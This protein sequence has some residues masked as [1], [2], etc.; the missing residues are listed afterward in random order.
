[1][2]AI[3]A[4]T[5]AGSPRWITRPL[6]PALLAYLACA[7]PALSTL[8]TSPANGPEPETGSMSRSRDR[9]KHRACIRPIP[10]TNRL[11]RRANDT[12]AYLRGDTLWTRT[13]PP[14]PANAVPLAS[15][16][17]LHE[18]NL[19]VPWQ[20]D[21]GT[22]LARIVADDTGGY[23]LL[24]PDGTAGPKIARQSG[25][26]WEMVD[27][28][29]NYVS[30]SVLAHFVSDKITSDPRTLH[31]AAG[32][33]EGMQLHESNL[34]ESSQAPISP[35]LRQS[36]QAT[37][38]L[39]VGQSFVETLPARLRDRDASVWTPNEVRIVAPDL[40]RHIGRPLAVYRD[41]GLFDFAVSADGAPVS[42]E[43]VPANA[44]R[45]NYDDANRYGRRGRPS[46]EYPS[47]FAAIEAETRASNSF[48]AMDASQQEHLF[49][50]ELA[51]AIEATPGRPRLERMHEHW[52]NPLP[53]SYL[54]KQ[55]LIGYSRLRQALFDRNQPLRADQENFL[56]MLLHDLL[57]RDRRVAIEVVRHD[58]G[59]RGERLALIGTPNPAGN[60][61]V[62]EADLDGEGRRIAYYQ[63]G[64]AGNGAIRSRPTTDNSFSPIID[65]LLNADNG[66]VR[67]AL[68]LGEWDFQKFAD[69]LLA[70][71]VENENALIPASLQRLVV[72]NPTV[73]TDATMQSWDSW[74][75]NG[76]HYVRLRN[77]AGRTQIVETGAPAPDG[78]RE[79]LDY[80]NYAAVRERGHHLLRERRGLWF[81]SS[82]IRAGFDPLSLSFRR[83]AAMSIVGN[84]PAHVRTDVATAA[85]IADAIPY[86]V[87]KDFMSHPSP[88]DVRTNG[89]LAL[90]VGHPISRTYLTRID[91][92]GRPIPVA[93]PAVATPR[94]ATPLS[95]QHAL[96]PAPQLRDTGSGPV[97]SADIATFNSLVASGAPIGE[98]ITRGVGSP[99]IQ[100]LVTARRW[101]RMVSEDE[102]MVL[103]GTAAGHVFTLAMPVNATAI[104][105]TGQEGVAVP[106][107]DLPPGTRII[108]DWYGVSA[109][110]ADY[111]RQVRTV[112]SQWERDG[113]QITMP[114]DEGSVTSSPSA[115]TERMLSTPMQFTFWSPATDPINETRYLGYIHSCYANPRETERAGVD[116]LESS[117]ARSEY[118]RYF[119]S[120]FTERASVSNFAELVTTTLDIDPPPADAGATSTALR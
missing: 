69:K 20:T 62:I 57:P 46:G 80:T 48:R 27:S 15:G 58:S 95:R 34:I 108:D 99:H 13:L 94:P 49:R 55:H 88:I 12:L 11:Y 66:K 115:F 97:S 102:H 103:V 118:T 117:A 43:A 59:E 53:V 77:L 28:P 107:A 8:A 56:L 32:I 45:L 90:T 110:I 96:T 24:L 106:V 112:A 31:H 75:L 33:L 1:M 35:D 30:G 87:M 63:R 18:G 72:T 38:M 85:R 76:R 98:F 109:T 93:P 41:T 119:P 50:I 52:L 51:A 64:A 39:A 111:P 25:G 54:R 83:D 37:V 21:T 17:I 67:K 26:R 4:D 91:I 47:I 68:E 81:P 100:A 84:L 74:S 29:D 114:T 10:R 14:V 65:V 101:R 86:P 6:L 70:R 19:H 104:R 73:L 113:Q 60:R 44:I 79:I 23:R 71:A 5:N 2:D 92:S 7:T 82:L 61:I 105:L 89:Q 16:T 9:G 40:A 78:T 120:D 116:W 36:F 3:P 42:P 22:G